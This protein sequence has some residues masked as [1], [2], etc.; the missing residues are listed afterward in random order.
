M[1]PRTKPQCCASENATRQLAEVCLPASNSDLMFIFSVEASNIRFSQMV[2]TACRAETGDT[3]Y[4]VD[5]RTYGCATAGY[6]CN[7]IV[8]T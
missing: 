8:L 3:Q 1:R 6:A 2:A 5:D 4:H 7:K